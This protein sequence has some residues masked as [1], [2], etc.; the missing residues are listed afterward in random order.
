[1][2]T[3]K[4]SYTA[5]VNVHKLKMNMTDLV[6]MHSNLEKKKQGNKKQRRR[7]NKN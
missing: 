1:M 7:E 6:K 3:N 2:S 5:D 4:H